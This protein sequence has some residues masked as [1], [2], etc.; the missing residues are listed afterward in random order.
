[1]CFCNSMRRYEQA[2]SPDGVL[3][4]LMNNDKNIMNRS[5]MLSLKF[6]DKLDQI[7]VCVI[8]RRL[9]DAVAAHAEGMQVISCQ[10][11]SVTSCRVTLYRCA[12]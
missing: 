3:L 1:M 7:D 11:P 2:D 9:E 4:R 5:T 8:E 10:I 12:L 6:L